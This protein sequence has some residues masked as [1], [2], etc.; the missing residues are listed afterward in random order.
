MK[1][2]SKYCSDNTRYAQKKMP[3]DGPAPVDDACEHIFS[4]LV[5]LVDIEVKIIVDDVPGCGNKN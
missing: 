2:D 4:R 3:D 5:D 1:S